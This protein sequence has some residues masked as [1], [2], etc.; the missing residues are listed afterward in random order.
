MRKGRLTASPIPLLVSLP[1]WP[2]LA[3]HL[4]LEQV[5]VLHDLLGQRLDQ[6]HHIGQLVGGEPVRQQVVPAV[7]VHDPD[8][9]TDDESHALCL[10]FPLVAR[11]GVPLLR[12][13]VSDGMDVLMDE[14][15]RHT[16]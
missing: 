8:G 6:F 1:R 11:P 14:A 4:G 9:A 10:P 12:C 13:S 7:D 5:E 16:P 3:P 15:G 2:R